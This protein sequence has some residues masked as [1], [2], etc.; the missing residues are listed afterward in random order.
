MAILKLTESVTF[1]NYI[2]P[3]CLANSA[4]NSITNGDVISWG[5]YDDTFRASDIPRR[6]KVPIIGNLECLRKSPGLLNIFPNDAFC[7]GKD[8][9]GVC[10]GDSGSG[11]YV[12]QNGKFYLRGIVS[13]STVSWCSDANLAIY[14]DVLKNLEFIEKVS[15]AEECFV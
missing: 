1:N 11:F 3:V 5:T 4:V 14:S 15:F 12:E 9:S 8:G 10:V 13:A 2:R 6:I 7:A